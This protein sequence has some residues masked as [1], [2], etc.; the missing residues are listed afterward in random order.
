M[1]SVALI[2]VIAISA[3]TYITTIGKITD[4]SLNTLKTNSYNTK[5]NIDVKINSID[6]IIKGVSSQPGF[7][8]ALEMVNNSKN[9]DTDVYSNVQISMKNAVDG[10]NKLVGAMYLCDSKGRIVA[11]GA[12]DY[13]QF[14]DK[15]FYD[16]KL[17]EDIKKLKD[18]VVVGEPVYSEEL[19]KLVIPISKP[20]RSLAAFSGSIT[21]LVDY[22][23][24]F[25]LISNSDGKSEIII[26]N[27]DQT[28]I[29][30]QNSEKLNTKITDKNL[31]GYLAGHS[32]AEYI[33][34]NDQK[35]KKVMYTDK[36]AVTNWIVCAQ[37]GYSAV[38]SSVRQYVLVISIVILLTLV[39]TLFVS[40]IYS[41][42]ISKPV[43]ELA[44]QMKKIEEGC[45]EISP[46]GIRANIQ[47][48][49]SLK[50]NFYNMAVN[51]KNLILN[52]TSASNE[53]DGMSGVMYEASC[54]SI[55]QTE[56][57]RLSVNKINENIKKQAEDTNLVAE[58]IDSLANQIATSRE[59]SQNVYGY[60]D[61]L[62][63]STENGRF[64]ID[65]L[66]SISGANL[67]NTDMMKDAVLQ[68]Q[69]QMKQINNVTD[70]IHN[71]AKQ[72][73]LLS[74]NATIEASRAGAA[75]KGFSVVAQEIKGL[76]EQTNIQTG[77]IRNMLD[78]IV[79]NTFLL[80]AVFKEVSAGTDTQSRAVS[81]TKQSF[82][83]IAGCIENINHQLYNINDY[84]R[85]M[86]SQKTNL[87]QLVNH[88]NLSAAEIAAGSNQVQSYTREQ[89]WSVNKMHD[90]SDKF[91][92]LAGTLKKSVEIF[93]V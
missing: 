4:L 57:T 5:N 17:F 38:M 71:I 81:R 18:G 20:V 47:E 10:S 91:K 33:T 2:P 9:L 48:I 77:V 85:E 14:K 44:E 3:S 39:I 24:F 23:N 42:Y 58:G 65:S 37:T 26:L 51:L 80:V 69:S 45:F 60:L 67:K 7:L 76:S 8:V 36:S 73:H 13:R 19:K 32:N 22:N 55:E 83:E 64:E 68:L 29:Y 74:L 86:D 34:Y 59:L 56:N 1:I 87:V 78:G 27:K 53:I 21:A 6:S 70:T 93:K 92:E 72:T 31:N 75:G 61:L 49:N 12:K 88:I 62:N 41:K 46:G 16:L 15:S 28:I 66:E 50:E 63:K 84:L 43:V 82:A 30:H 54:S 90:D 89:Q 11:A 35:I 79:K 40:I 25:T 52:I